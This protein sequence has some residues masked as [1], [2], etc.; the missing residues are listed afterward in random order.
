MIVIGIGFWLCVAL[1]AYTYAGYPLA[2]AVLARCCRRESA[3]ASATDRTPSVTLL[4]S[5]CDEQ[6]VIA[7]RLDNALALDYPRDRLQILVAADGSHDRTAD[8]VRSYAGRGV[9]LSHQSQRQGKMAAI[10]RAMTQA[11]GDIVVFSDANNRY[12]PATLRELVGPFAEAAVGATSGA[13]SILTGDGVL[14]DAEGLY[15]KYE[16]FIKRQEARLGCC[17][18]V[19]GEV[20]AIRRELFEAAPPNI[21][22]DDFYLAMRIV[23]RGYRIAYAPRARSWERI[24]PTA[25]DEVMRRARIVA[26]R[27]QAMMLA[28]RWLPLRRPLVV[29]QIVSHK[30]L[31]PLVV[32]AMA[33]A[34]VTNLVAVIAPVEVAP[35]AGWFA[36]LV[37]L[38]WPMN[39]IMLSLQALFYAAA[40]AGALIGR[41]H[42]MGKLLYVPTFLVHSNFAALLG[43]WRALAGRQTAIWQRLPRRDS[44]G[45][46][47][48]VNP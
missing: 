41:D 35:S 7:G 38:R 43:L 12:D 3:R 45:Q 20:L 46:Q 2:V 25:Q 26:G 15:W 6:A 4:I 27:Y 44:D 13:K 22:N 19:A 31:R 8:I 1:V 32:L 30:F 36:A 34:W 17:T 48:G 42:V 23:R 47:Q 14:G 18:S 9:E 24:S 29:W 37:Q 21:I 11:R 5:A 40:A 10:N 39:W 16:S 33:G 28:A